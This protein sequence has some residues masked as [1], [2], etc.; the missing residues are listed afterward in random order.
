M[1]ALALLG[2]RFTDAASAADVGAF[3]PE[4]P[5]TLPLLRR[6]ISANRRAND[7][8]AVARLAAL[9]QSSRVP[10][11]ARLLAIDALAEWPAPGP[12]EPVQGRALAIDPASRDAAAWKRTLASRLPG[13]VSSAPDETV[14]TKIGRAHV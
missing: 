6:V 14:R 12:R 4:D 3:T 10:A 5:R 7:A 13:L 2:D 9:A 11:A 8:A 1:P